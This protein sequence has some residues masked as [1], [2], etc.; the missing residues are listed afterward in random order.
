MPDSHAMTNA[1]LRRCIEN[2]TACH[3]AC[4]ETMAHCLGRGG[5]H[6]ARDHIRLLA[7]CADI[8]RTSADFMLRGSAH[9]AAV[10]AVC[11]EI[12][13]LC[14][15]ECEAFPD[16]DAMMRDCADACRRCAASCAQMAA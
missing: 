3:A 13:E 9:H 15:A 5:A 16:A 1:D 8:C 6:A 14:A 2:C 11:A 12:C 7:D 4:L 10:C